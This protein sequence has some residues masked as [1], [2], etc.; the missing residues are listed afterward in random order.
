MKKRHIAIIGAGIAAT[1][2]LVMSAPAHCTSQGS[3]PDARCT[4]GALNT[5][6]TQ[7]NLKDTLCNPDWSTKSIR[8][9]SSY[10]TMLKKNQIKQYGYID[11]STASYEEDHLISLELGGSPTDPNNLWPE[12]YSTTPGAR[13]KDRVENYLHAQVCAGAITL[14]AAQKEISTDWVAV[15]RQSTGYPQSG[16]Q[17]YGSTQPLTDLDDE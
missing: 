4:P 12:S 15:Y 17:Q 11:T 6:I 8:P 2:A 5:Q 7:E 10:T 1:A 16:S 3:L 9:P 13:E 14:A